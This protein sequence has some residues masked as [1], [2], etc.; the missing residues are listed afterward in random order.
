[1]MT[2]GSIG[3]GFFRM[4]IFESLLPRAPERD[5]LPTISDHKEHPV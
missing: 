1:M 2:F 4:L 5:I 3:I